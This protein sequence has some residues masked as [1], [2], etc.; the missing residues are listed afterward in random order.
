MIDTPEREGLC[1]HVELQPLDRRACAELVQALL[2][3]SRVDGA[4]VD[5]V[6]AS[7]LGNP[8]FI[9]ELL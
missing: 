4:L 5:H 8:L 9:Q 2:P 7:S 1:V 3:G 6:Y